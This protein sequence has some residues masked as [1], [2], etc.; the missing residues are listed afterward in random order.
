KGKIVMDSTYDG[1][2]RRFSVFNALH[3]PTARCN[4]I[5]GSRI[6]KKGVSTRTGNGKITYLNTA[7]VPFASGGIVKDLYKMDVVPVEPDSAHQSD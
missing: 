7:E 3:I 5:S 1:V 2:K 4:L 6:D